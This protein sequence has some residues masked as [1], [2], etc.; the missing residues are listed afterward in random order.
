MVVVVLLGTQKVPNEFV[1]TAEVLYRVYVVA[2]QNISPVVVKVL[3]GGQTHDAIF[4]FAV[5]DTISTT[6]A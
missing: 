2:G 3:D 6:W 4:P 5:H 1:A